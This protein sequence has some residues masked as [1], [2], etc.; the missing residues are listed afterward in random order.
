MKDE[1][2]TLARLQRLDFGQPLSIDQVRTR[3]HRRRTRRRMLVASASAVVVFGAASYVAA[4]R[5]GNN[6]RRVAVNAP[7]STAAP[8]N[9]TS[10]PSPP[11]TPRDHS[12]IV[13]SKTDVFVLGGT[14]LKGAALSDGARFN[15][16]QRQWQHV[17]DLPDGPTASLKGAW[18]GEHLVV[19]SRESAF[20]FDAT[21]DAWRKLAPPPFVVA[22]DSVLTAANDHLVLWSPERSVAASLDVVSG[23][24]T[25]VSPPPVVG[26]ASTLYWDGTELVALATESVDA[27]Q[28]SRLVVAAT[29]MPTVRWRALPPSPVGDIPV[30]N[31]GLG[32]TLTSIDRNGHASTLSIDD[33]SWK[34]L[35][36]API[37]GCDSEPVIIAMPPNQL[38]LASYCGGAAVFDR[39]G[40]RWNVI[41]DALA[42]I[43][44]R[45]GKDS[46]QWTSAG[47]FAWNGGCCGNGSAAQTDDPAA[48]LFQGF[49]P[50]G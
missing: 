5:G 6:D 37:S 31:A 29:E 3:A 36:A 9:W 4:S 27:G 10:L 11:L 41:A 35:N 16:E 45:A 30:V 14:D 18:T 39:V 25:P 46:L 8:S 32:R 20:F 38:L 26:S 28:T 15:L 44:R 13:T 1:A 50:G 19:V 49:E 34:P 2:D 47:L 22:A 12:L 23:S 7:P 33:S 42:A 40:Q 21:G 43:P 17:A 24:W 48:W